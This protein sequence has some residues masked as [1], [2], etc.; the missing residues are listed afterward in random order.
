MTRAGAR[1]SDRGT[2]GCGTRDSFVDGEF[3]TY[4]IDQSN[5]VCLTVVTKVSKLNVTNGFLQEK[6]PLDEML[7]N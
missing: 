2:E 6:K 1:Q 3:K 5:D 4:D 7:L